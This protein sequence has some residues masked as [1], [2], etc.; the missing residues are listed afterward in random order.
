MKKR[1][2]SVLLLA[3]PY[4][5]TVFFPVI[6]VLFLGYLTISDYNQKIIS[7]RQVSITSAF[8]RYVQRMSEVESLAYIIAQNDTTVQYT[9]SS[10]RG[11]GHTVEENIEFSNLL[12]DSRVSDDILTMYFYDSI[13]NTIVSPTVALSNAEEYF[14]Y[15]YRLEGYSSDASL[16]RLRELIG[17]NGFGT[18]VPAVVDRKETEVIEYRLPLPLNVISSGRSQL[19]M[20]S[21]TN[22]VCRDLFDVLDESCE[23][24]IYDRSGQ[25]IYGSGKRY[26]ALS[27]QEQS[28][29][30]EKVKY[31][32]ET[33]YS[34][35]SRSS[36]R[37]WTLKVYTPS[38]W[39]EDDAMPTIPVVVTLMTA[40]ILLSIVLAIYFTLK[41]NREI[42]ELTSLFAG[43]KEPERQ[44]FDVREGRFGEIREK[45]RTLI[46]EN[47]S[48][49]ESQV[50][51]EGSRRYQIL[52]RLLRSTYE[53]RE[54]LLAD[55][56]SENL[57]LHPGRQVVICVHYETAG[58]EQAKQLREQIRQKM[59]S[60]TQQDMEVFT[61]SPTETV[62]IL[63]ADREET[64][65]WLQRL[66]SSLES[67][68]QREFGI[69][70]KVAAGNVAETLSLLSEAC[71]QARAV[72]RY[73]EIS[74]KPVAL[75]A[76]LEH[77][78]D[79]FFCPKK[80]EEAMYN[81]VVAGRKEEACS[82]L[83]QI[84]N[85]NFG[86]QARLLS[87]RAI[88]ALKGRLKDVLLSAAERYEV[89]IDNEL[90][91]TD[92]RQNIPAF[93]EMLL[94]SLCVLAEKIAGRKKAG[95]QH[96]AERIMQYVNEHFT[97]NTI[98]VK[99]IALDLG[100]HENYVSTLFRSEYGETL[101]GVIEKKRI[102]KAC[103]LLRNT[104]MKVLS[105]AELV[106]YSS[107]VSFRRAFKKI[108]GM[109][110]AEYRGD[111]SGE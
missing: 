31:G 86:D 50:R 71:M 18:S 8:E 47:T 76:E 35:V 23:F 102:E 101:S 52:D 56:T 91:L 6:S 33:L 41:N 77:A 57:A 22:D 43:K 61:A 38:F 87:V 100:L 73:R 109:S 46:H 37:K 99:Q 16:A 28:H 110:P 11:N 44:D 64:H 17:A 82:I 67:E 54:E 69:Q 51:Y 25:L 108:M 36:D 48:L 49:R 81:A 2:W 94:E 29:A 63:S 80:C 90:L 24:Y 12:R 93:F 9:Y 111:H 4:M 95:Q 97:N 39:V 103:E 14:K 5:I 34:M 40:S 45:A 104:N 72:I 10:L 68:L 21:E 42:Q 70:V 15:T 1:I 30:L 20:V 59:R 84:Y 27:D 98:C 58:P 85:E 79:V 55:L 83:T 19:V 89:P 75:Y 88:E 107:D 53:S 74:G 13:N 105:I 92:D 106:G 32:D 65:P 66:I 7:D 78:H 62:C 96:S 60:I 26:Q 3:L